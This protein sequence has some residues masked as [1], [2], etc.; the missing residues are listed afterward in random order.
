LQTTWWPQNICIFKKKST[1]GEQQYLKSQKV[2]VCT[3]FD[4]KGAANAT[5]IPL[6]QIV[7]LP[8]ALLT[9]FAI[10]LCAQTI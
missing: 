8:K 9:L 7:I 4:M 6:L 1:P 5:K 3:L 2:Y 10:S